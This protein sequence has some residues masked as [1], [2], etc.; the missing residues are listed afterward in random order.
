LTIAAGKAA[1]ARLQIVRKCAFE[2]QMIFCTT[3]DDVF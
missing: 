1:H 3:A 2:N